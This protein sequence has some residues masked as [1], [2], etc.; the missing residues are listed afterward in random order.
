[1]TPVSDAW[2]SAVWLPA[3]MVQRCLCCCLVLA[4][5]LAASALAQDPC[6]KFSWDIAHEH[7][8]FATSAQSLTAGH[9]VQSAPLLASNR[10]YELQLGAQS[11]VSMALPSGKK[12]IPDGAFAGLAQLRMTQAGTYRVSMDQPAWIDVVADGK[13]I[14]SADA[15]GRAGCAAPHKIVQYSLPA[16][17]ELVLQFSAA[18]NPRVRL[19]IT[20][21]EAAPT[22]H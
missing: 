6:A 2:R 13:M 21:V 4:L 14:D 1:M 12:S 5:G 7:A 15:Q 22:Q 16:A 10:L 3:R 19:T 17:R 9:D 11:Q 8:L 20:R 18:A